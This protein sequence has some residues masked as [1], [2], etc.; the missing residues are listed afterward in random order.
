MDKLKVIDAASDK[1]EKRISRRRLL[2]GAGAAGL[3]A[4]VAGGC[5]SGERPVASSKPEVNADE[6]IDGTVS[7]T[8]AREIISSLAQDPELYSGRLDPHDLIGKTDAELS[9]VPFI[10][11]TPE[12][13]HDDHAAADA[14]LQVLELFTNAGL[15]PEDALLAI[16]KGYPVGERDSLGN[17]LG[18][19]VEYTE[20][21][22]G[23]ISEG[24]RYERNGESSGDAVG[25]LLKI[26]Q[27][28]ARRF[29][30]NLVPR[31]NGSKT[32]NPDANLSTYF[33]KDS[34]M[35]VDVPESYIDRCLSI[36]TTITYNNPELTTFYRGSIGVYLLD[37]GNEY[38]VVPMWLRLSSGD[39]S[40][41]S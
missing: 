37:A 17:V 36:E 34:I 28:M 5:S 15:T 8:E 25:G 39:K 31:R 27:E 14:A 7:A 22:T 13:E 38:Q 10:S 4:M 26:Q 16:E 1:D 11:K 19:F 12:I 6:Y 9:R 2:L 40:I 29:Q 18:R 33:M 20:E 24:F 41:P 32:R 21:Y 23:P 35:N 3:V 30:N